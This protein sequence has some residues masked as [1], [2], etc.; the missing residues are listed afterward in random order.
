MD[1][2]ESLFVTVRH[3]CGPDG[4]LQSTTDSRALRHSGV[5]GDVIGPSQDPAVQP[6]DVVGHC[7]VVES[8]MQHDGVWY[9]GI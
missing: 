7:A 9:V 8:S 6:E 4:P 5:G 1:L 3:G 2:P